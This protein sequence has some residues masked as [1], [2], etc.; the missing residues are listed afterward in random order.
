MPRFVLDDDCY[1]LSWSESSNLKGSMGV[2]VTEVYPVSDESFCSDDSQPIA[3]LHP[4]KTGSMIHHEL[5][6]N[7]VVID[8]NMLQKL[9]E[10]LYDRKLHVNRQVSEEFSGKEKELKDLGLELEKTKEDLYLCEKQLDEKDQEL[11][12]LSE[13]LAAK[14]NKLIIGNIYREYCSN[15]SFEKRLQK[16][17]AVSRETHV[18]LAFARDYDDNNRHTDRKF[19]EFFD[20]DVNP[21]LITNFKKNLPSNSKVKLFLC[22]GNRS[23][24]YPFR[25]TDKYRWVNNATSSLERIIKH[26]GFDGIDVYYTS[27]S[28]NAKDFVY[29]IG[30]VIDELMEQR[31]ITTASLALSPFMNRMDRNFYDTLYKKKP[32]NFDYVVYQTHDDA[33][34]IPLIDAQALIT[35]F[36][37][38]A[39]NHNFP[40]EKL[41]AGHSILPKDWDTVPYPVIFTALPKLIKDGTI[42]GTSMWAITDDQP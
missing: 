7:G 39:S 5:E 11:K 23:Q 41:L 24:K 8:G 27:S 22:I 2:S 12:K 16:L 42:R 4:Q 38:L 28:S 20:K 36:N 33:D 18:V 21:D 26:Y 15:K 35:I 17:S 32:H 14:K 13:R 10:E 25:I 40:K 30:T 31:I 6:I 37:D 29:A 3:Y 9:I 34:S 1:F 19:K